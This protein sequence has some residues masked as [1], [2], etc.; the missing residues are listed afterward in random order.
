MK[1]S[2]LI[3]FLGFTLLALNA[4]APVYRTA[5]IYGKP[6]GKEGLQCINSCES[7][8]QACDSACL[9]RNDACVSRAQMDANL[10]SIANAVNGIEVQATPQTSSCYAEASSC[11]SACINSYNECYQNCGGQ[12]TP[13]TICVQFCDKAP[14][15]TLMPP[16]SGY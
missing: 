7:A 6:T 11:Q 4:C 2:V 13:Y 9:Q 14:A 15:S 1:K 10:K 12:V 3:I 16:P 8:R 5:F